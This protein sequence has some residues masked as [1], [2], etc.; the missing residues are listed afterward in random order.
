MHEKDF[1][2]ETRYNLDYLG[3]GHLDREQ[4]LDYMYTGHYVEKN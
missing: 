1:F 4:L 2:Q 3:I